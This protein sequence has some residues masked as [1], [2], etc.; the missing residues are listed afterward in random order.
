MAFV[1][2]ILHKEPTAKCLR[3]V[4]NQSLKCE[5]RFRR[6]V[7]SPKLRLKHEPAGVVGQYCGLGQG[8][9]AAP[10]S[11]GR[12]LWLQGARPPWA[13]ASPLSTPTR[14]GTARPAPTTTRPAPGR[15]PRGA[16]AGDPHVP[17]GRPSGPQDVIL[18][19]RDAS[20]PESELQRATVLAALRG[21]RLPAPLLAGVLEVHNKADLLP[22]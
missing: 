7:S 3:L 20:H 11:W 6:R 22:G 21:L 18:H 13:P 5:K 12:A 16:G 4:K 10:R 9:P 2:R 14:S 1:F 15:P 8:D 19:V 17:A